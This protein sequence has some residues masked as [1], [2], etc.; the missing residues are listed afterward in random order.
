MERERTARKISNQNIGQPSFRAFYFIPGVGWG[1]VDVSFWFLVCNK[2]ISFLSQAVPV[3]DVM[4][5][6]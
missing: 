6:W 1:R 4:S 2:H 5:T 3:S